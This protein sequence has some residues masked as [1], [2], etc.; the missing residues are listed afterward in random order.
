MAEELLDR[1]DVRPAFEQVCGERV[2]ERVAA[3][4]LGQPRFA[5]RLGHRPLYDRLV[6]VKPRRRT[7]P[8]IPADPPGGKG[9][10]A[11]QSVH[12]LGY[13]RSRAPGNTTRPYRNRAFWVWRRGVFSFA[14]LG[15]TLAFVALR[16]APLRYGRTQEHAPPH[17]IRRFPTANCRR[18]HG[19]A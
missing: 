5:P 19:F 17:T 6:Q 18:L 1:A 8:L 2:P 4:A 13:L 7:K 9:R 14:G 11:P 12:A 16:Q 10:T 3:D 15:P